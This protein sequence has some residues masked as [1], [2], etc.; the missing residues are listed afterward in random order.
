MKDIQ[1]PSSPVIVQLFKTNLAGRQWH[2][3]RTTVPKSQMSGKAKTKVILYRLQPLY[4]NS[5]KDETIQLEYYR[6]LIIYRL[7]CAP[8][9]HLYFW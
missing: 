4:D 2:C 5:M 7:C 1:K 3:K 6:S 9:V 8:T